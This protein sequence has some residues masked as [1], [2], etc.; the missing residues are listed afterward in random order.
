MILTESC[1]T[2]MLDELEIIHWAKYIDRFELRKENI[3]LEIFFIGLA[4]KLLLN[5]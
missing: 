4:T 2:L 1:K 3:E 5:D